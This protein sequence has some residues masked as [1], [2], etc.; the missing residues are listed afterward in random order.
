MGKEYLKCYFWGLKKIYKKMKSKILLIGG[1]GNL[2]SEIIKSNLF[3]NIVAPSKKK[4]NILFTDQI[5]NIL[6]RYSP[7]II[8][9]CASL[10]RMKKCEKDKAKA[11]NNNILE[12]L[13]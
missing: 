1:S 7:K 5:R 6:H 9:H 13:I 4:L 3:N 8:I 10:A 12:L 2:G 11:I